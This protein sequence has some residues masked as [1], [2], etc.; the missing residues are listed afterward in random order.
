[1]KFGISTSCF[2][3][4]Q[5]EEAIRSL[6]EFGPQVIEIFLNTY[7]ETT[8]EFAKRMKAILDGSGIQAV[9]V[10]PFTSGMES[11]LFFSEYQGRM[12]DSIQRYQELY[13]DFLHQVGANILVLHGCMNHVT[14]EDECYFER[15]AKMREAARREGI[16]LAQENVAPFKSH[17]VKFI[18]KMKQYLD[19]QVEFVFDIKQSVRAGENPWEML[20]AMGKNMV[21]THVSDHRDQEDCLPIGN[22]V[23]DFSNYFNILHASSFQG[24]AVIEL[25]RHNYRSEKDLFDSY[26]RLFHFSQKQ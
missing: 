7:S 1:M 14:I 10:H 17:S 16:I 13:F 12:E 15:F 18:R 8:P 9:S 2:Y 6:A 3:P 19:G 26:R 20:E 4:G 21:H 24:A 11:L 22:G 23:F 5:T 25:Y